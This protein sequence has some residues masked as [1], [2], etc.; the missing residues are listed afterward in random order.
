MAQSIQF[1]NGHPGSS[2]VLNFRL[3]IPSGYILLQLKNF[4]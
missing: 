2:K 4:K 1:T 3:T